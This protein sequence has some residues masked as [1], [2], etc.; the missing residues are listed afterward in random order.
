MR[1]FMNTN[2]GFRPSHSTQHAIMT[3]GDLITKSF[4]NGNIA[5]S[6]A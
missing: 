6:F 1:H 3:L 5:S 2:L 4:D